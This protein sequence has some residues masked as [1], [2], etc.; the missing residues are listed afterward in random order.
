M[1][2]KLKPNRRRY[3]AMRMKIVIS[4]AILVMAM[5]GMAFADSLPDTSDSF[6]YSLSSDVT[7][8][9]FTDGTAGNSV[10]YVMNSKN[11]AGNRLFSSTDVT[12]KIFYKED[13]TNYP[14]KDMVD[15]GSYDMDTPGADETSDYTTGNGWKAL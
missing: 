15:M 10:H 3:S 7:F 6:K 8:S 12:S 11:K 5:G 9:Y 13:D 4:A 2:D 1:I 14:G